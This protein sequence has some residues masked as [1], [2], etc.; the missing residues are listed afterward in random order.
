MTAQMT[1]MTE[2]STIAALSHADG[3]AARYQDA[4][5]LVGRILMG[6]IFVQSG[7]GKL[8]DIPGFAAGLARQGVPGSTFWAYIGAPV[9][10][11][12]GLALLL[13]FATRYAALLMIL[14]VIAATLISHRYWE[15]A[16]ATQRR[17]QN[18]NFYKNVA[19]IGGL[20]FLFVSAGGRFSIDG[21][22]RRR[23]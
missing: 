3:C 17:I 19:M 11:F 13:G 22:L 5:L 8:M 2:P 12:G 10:F 18:V 23:G 1:N 6:W 4:L 14:F 9:E 21:W 7:W 16:E 20:F 15:F